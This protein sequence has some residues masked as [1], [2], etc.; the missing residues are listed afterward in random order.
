MSP[1][2]MINVHT[3]FGIKRNLLDGGLG[4]I[5]KNYMGRSTPRRPLNVKRIMIY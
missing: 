3:K 2:G 4:T 5:N 1:K